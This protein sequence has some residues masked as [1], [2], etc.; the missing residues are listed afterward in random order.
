MT[1]KLDGLEAELAAMRPRALSREL[2]ERID[3]DLAEASAPSKWPDRF[4]VSAIGA[5]AIA[6]SVIVAMLL[7][8]MSEGLAA[9]VP[10]VATVP[11]APDPPRAGDFSL[12]AV[13]R[14][15]FDL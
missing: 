15:E 12:A 7:K 8:P 10:V 2:I 1:D 11:A 5:G 9:P 6:A 13:A 3:D 4:L 14:A